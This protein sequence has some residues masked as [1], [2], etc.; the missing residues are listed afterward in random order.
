MGSRVVLV[1]LAAIGDVAVACRAVNDFYSRCELRNG[2][3]ELHW[4][5]DHDLVGL[6]R[7]LLD[8]DIQPI[9]HTVNSVRIF[10]GSAVEKALEALG[11]L[12]TVAF[13]RP[14]HILMFHRDWRYKALL[15]P[16]I[17]ASLTSVT[18]D[19]LHE[20]VAYQRLFDALAQRL[21]LPPRELPSHGQ[22]PASPS[23]RIG[24]LVGGA[25]SQKVDFAEKRWPRIPELTRL[26]LEKT[27]AKIVLFGGPDDTAAAAAALD[28]LS[29]DGRVENLV[30]KLTLAEV[31]ATLAGLDAFIS[32]DSG[33]AHIAAAVMTSKHQRVITLFGPTDPRIWA[34][35]A[36][37]NA[38]TKLHYK[39][40]PCSPCYSGDGNFKP[41]RFEGEYFQ[42]CMTGISAEEVLRSLY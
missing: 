35:L 39:A 25:R 11:I 22:I 21:H 5:I 6:A 3:I 17:G 27:Q 1:K 42:H 12:K 37:G 31:P 14:D 30:G 4:I 33:L 24:I 20:F 18:R 29:I 15:R 36:S 26:L 8:P 19:P 23:G 10:Q 2:R 13:L 38:N 40:P 7:A 41:C 28:G 16:V 34:P 32:I 9:W